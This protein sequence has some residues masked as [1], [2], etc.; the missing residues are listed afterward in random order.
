M[1]TRALLDANFAPHRLELEVT[2]SIFLRN[3]DALLSDLH[4]LHNVGIRLALDDFGTGYSSLGYLRKLPFDKIKID[5]TFIRDLGTDAQSA[6]II[7]AVANLARSLD[8]DTTAEG[9]ETE[10]QAQLVAAAGCT[11][12][13]GYYFGHPMPSSRLDFGAAPSEQRVA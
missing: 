12:A 10:E 13:Q 1:V 8:M 4:Q 5:K 2:E 6:A 7:C 11:L 3:D 9:V